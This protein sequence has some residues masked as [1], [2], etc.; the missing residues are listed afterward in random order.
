MTVDAGL[1]N[2]RITIEAIGR[3]TANALGE[4][5]P[6]WTPLS[7]RCAQVRETMGRE[8][9]AGSS[10]DYRAEHRVVFVVRWIEIDSTARVK[11]GG[12]IYRI[13]DVTG[14]Y[15]SGETWLHCT[16]TGETY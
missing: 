2:Q 10:G 5:S 15:H 8:F 12:R 13:D 4:T 3:S 11:W 9:L 6:E 1:L 16:T 7:D 14:T